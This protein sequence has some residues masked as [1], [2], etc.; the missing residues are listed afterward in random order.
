MLNYNRYKDIIKSLV[1]S[2]AN[3]N[4]EDQCKLV[5]SLGVEEIMELNHEI[6]K[7]EVCEYL[8]ITLEE[9]ES[10]PET[11]ECNYAEMQY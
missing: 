9:Y 2:V 8:G 11:H 5:G 10:D 4:Y 6:H 7:Q 1:K 3:L